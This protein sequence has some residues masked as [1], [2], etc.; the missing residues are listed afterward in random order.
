[1]VFTA[2]TTHTS[3]Y[4]EE[5]IHD[6]GNVG[7]EPEFQTKR[8]GLGNRRSVASRQAD[9]VLNKMIAKIEIAAELGIE[10][11]GDMPGYELDE[12]I[13]K[14]QRRTHGHEPEEN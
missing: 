2:K 11:P 4:S 9:F 8:R 6:R 1:M 10:N 5:Y 3:P 7:L 13:E 14:A 12:L